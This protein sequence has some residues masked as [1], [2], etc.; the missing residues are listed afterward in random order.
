MQA[1]N[2]SNKIFKF[3]IMDFITDLAPCKNIIIGKVTNN[4]LIIVD[5]YFKDVEYISYLKIINALEL[6]CLFITY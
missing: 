4:L 2:Q 3:I 5:K 6:A 1:P